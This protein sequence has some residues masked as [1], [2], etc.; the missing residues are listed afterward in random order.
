MAEGAVLAAFSRARGGILYVQAASQTREAVLKPA[1]GL[2]RSGM[3]VHWHQG[4]AYRE[5]ERLDAN[6]T[7]VRLTQEQVAS[8]PWDRLLVD[9]C[10]SSRICLRLTGADAQA[11]FLRRTRTGTFVETRLFLRCD[12]AWGV[13]VAMGLHPR[14]GGESRLG[15]LGDELVRA[16]LDAISTE[17]DTCLY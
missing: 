11:A 10:T 16:I 12:P 6:G 9:S 1:A 14:L 8:V 2:P 5:P 17:Q 15:A 13:A 4:R 3:F 7:R